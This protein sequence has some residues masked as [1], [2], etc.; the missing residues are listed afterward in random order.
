MLL[1][2][3]SVPPPPVLAEGRVSSKFIGALGV[4]VDAVAKCVK[5]SCEDSGSPGPP[6]LADPKW[7]DVPAISEALKKK[8][9]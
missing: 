2:G 5:R 1:T 9:P 3:D 4:D 8:K 7:S 6:L